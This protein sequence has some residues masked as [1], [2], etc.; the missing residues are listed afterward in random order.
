MQQAGP[1]GRLTNRRP[2]HF[3]FSVRIQRPP[4]STYT[5][6]VTWGQVTHADDPAIQEAG[7]QET[8]NVIGNSSVLATSPDFHWGVRRPDHPLHGAL[9]LVSCSFEFVN[10]EVA[11]DQLKEIFQ[12]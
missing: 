1:H 8:R 6:V 5:D 10:H 3:M 9:V 7:L 4:P 11:I 12:N 2:F